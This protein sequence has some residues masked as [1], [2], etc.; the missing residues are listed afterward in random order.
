M[1]VSAQN[2]WNNPDWPYQPPNPPK[3]FD[4]AKKY[5]KL[6]VRFYSI[7][8]HCDMYVYIISTSFVIKVKN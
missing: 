4:N 8:V 6:Q 3:Y 5:Q 1:I 2:E 7:F